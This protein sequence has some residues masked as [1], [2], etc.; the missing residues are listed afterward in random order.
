MNWK[1]FAKKSLELVELVSQLGPSAEEKK[2]QA[3]QDIESMYD[4]ACY[5]G[6]MSYSTAEA[7]KDEFRYSIGLEK[8]V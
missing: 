4:A 8:K 3:M 7:Y 5:S 6:S 1:K 2:Q